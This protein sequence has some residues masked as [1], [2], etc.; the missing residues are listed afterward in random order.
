MKLSLVPPPCVPGMICFANAIEP[1]TIYTSISITT[2]LQGGA[3][4]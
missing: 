3:F 4:K 2:Y 1:E